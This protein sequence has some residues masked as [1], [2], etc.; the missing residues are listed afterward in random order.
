MPIKNVL[1]AG[2]E[3]L[4]AGA[5]G[6]VAADRLLIYANAKAAVIQAHLAKSP[7]LTEQ[8]YQA[9][10]QVAEQAVPNGDL[11]L[12]ILYASTA[13]LL[14]GFAIYNASRQD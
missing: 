11:F 13:G 9:A 4:L 12:G 10:R 6:I 1:L 3:G 8:V 14:G 5:N 7:E 2:L